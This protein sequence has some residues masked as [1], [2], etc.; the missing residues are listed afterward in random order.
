MGSP[1]Y[2]VPLLLRS[3]E[4]TTDSAGCQRPP[5]GSAKLLERSRR[6][7]I[8]FEAEAGERRRGFPDAGDDFA[9]LALQ[10]SHLPTS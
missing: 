2:G 1:N 7:L 5:H 4:T 10:R 9:Q 3:T 6:L 8:V